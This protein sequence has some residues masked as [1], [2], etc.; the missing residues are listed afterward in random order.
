M[1]QISVIIPTWNSERTIGACLDSLFAQTVQ[2][3]EVI[4]VNDG[5]TDRTADVL[6]PY[7]SRIISINQENRG[8][9]AARN[10]GLRE[11]HGEYLLFLDS[12]ITMRPDMLLKL[13][14][15]LEMHP[16][17]SY[18][19]S[20][21]L[22]GRKLFR[23]WPFEATRLRRMPYIHTAAFV[24]AKDF[25]GFDEGVRRLQDWDVWLTLLEQDK[26]GVRVPEVLFTVEPRRDG[27]S[28]W[29]PRWFYWIPWR[30]IGWKPRR[31]RAYEEAVRVIREKH[32]LKD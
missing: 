12:D 32:K 3:F 2:D 13:L 6:A 11:A 27:I 18:A 24:R 17:A 21:F 28:Q 10:R 25:S 7:H 1:P 26:I 29:V 22:Y 15:A 4:V 20:S 8:S 19:Y 5:S 23:L 14:R 31:V 16:E 30:L 9:N